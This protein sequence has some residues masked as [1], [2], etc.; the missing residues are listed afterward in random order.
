M[1]QKVKIGMALLFVVL[2]GTFLLARTGFLPARLPAL[3]DFKAGEPMNEVLLA[4]RHHY[5]PVRHKVASGDAVTN[6]FGITRPLVYQGRVIGQPNDEASVYCSGLLLDLY[7]RAAEES[8]GQDFRIPGVTI[9]NFRDFRRDWYGFDGNERTLVNALAS[10]EIGIEIKEPLDAL[11]GDFVQFWRGRT[12]HSALFLGW[13]RDD[14]NR[15]I[16]IRY[17]SAQNA[18]N[19]IAEH[20]E[21]FRG[22]GGQVDPER[23]YIVRALRPHRR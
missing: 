23:V 7:F 14:N 3:P 20:V 4:Q 6:S 13:D 22:H 18:T 12:G 1:G 19:G 21:H 17:W 11:P 9:S 16:G 2:A 8:A 10:R 5:D 15:I